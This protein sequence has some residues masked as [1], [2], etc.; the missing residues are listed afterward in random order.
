MKTCWLTMVATLMLTTTGFAQ[1]AE[2]AGPVKTIR[3]QYEKALKAAQDKVTRAY[4][5]SLTALK[6]STRDTKVQK[7][8]LTEIEEAKATLKTVGY[9]KPE[10][11]VLGKWKWCDSEHIWYIKKGGIVDSLKNGAK[12]KWQIKDG[13][14]FVDFGSGDTHTLKIEA[15]KKM[16]TGTNPNGSSCYITRIEK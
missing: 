10:E 3:V 15:G 5:E 13:D 2:L 4:I 9:A 16:W 14:L 11:L 7:D 8:A 6:D 12:A 1:D